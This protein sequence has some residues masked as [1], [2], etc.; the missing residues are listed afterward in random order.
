MVES[1]KHR[2]MKEE[3]ERKLKEKGVDF[4]SSYSPGSKGFGPA[5]YIADPIEEDCSRSEL[6]I[7]LIDIFIEKIDAAL[8]LIIIKQLNDNY[9]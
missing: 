2:K 1:D 9:R 5:L 4:I 7:S 3:V 8:R 6:Q